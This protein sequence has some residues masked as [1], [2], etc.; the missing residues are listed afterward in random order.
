MVVGNPLLWMWLVAV[1]AAALSVYDVARVTW[2]PLSWLLFLFAAVVAVA[3]A[4]LAIPMVAAHVPAWLGGAIV[5]GP[6]AW[7]VVFGGSKK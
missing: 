6:A 5:G 7:G 3:S 1:L 2:T 4:M